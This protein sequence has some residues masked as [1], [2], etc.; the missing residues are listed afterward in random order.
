ML[1]LFSK[2]IFLK[3][4]GEWH[5]L[6]SKLTDLLI[7]SV[8]CNNTR[9][10][11]LKQLLVY[12]FWTI[13]DWNWWTKVKYRRFL[14]CIFILYSVHVYQNFSLVLLPYTLWLTRKQDVL[15]ERLELSKHDIHVKHY[16]Y[17]SVLISW[18]IKNGKNLNF[19]LQQWSS[20]APH[21]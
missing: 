15:L 16:V 7:A 11:P 5:V 20:V 9:I 2:M 12:V 6:K 19:Q 3:Y 18:Y 8:L 21:N 17:F 1:H 14:E 10:F 13:V 4:D